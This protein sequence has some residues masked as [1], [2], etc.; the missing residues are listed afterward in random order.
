MKRF[1]NMTAIIAGGAG[2][3]GKAVALALVNEGAKLTVW[4][5][6]AAALNELRQEVTAAGAQIVTDQ[7]DVTDYDAVKAA[8]DK[9]VKTFGR[10]DIMVS[11]VGGGTFK[12]LIE[13][14]NEFWLK[15]QNYNLNSVFNCFH[16]SLLHMVKQEFGRLFCFMSTTGGVPGLAGY[17]AAKAGC[18]ALMEN[19]KAEHSRQH[20]TVNAVL[21]SFTPTPFSMQAFDDSE[22][23][24]AR[25]NAIVNR[26][27]LGVNTVENVAATVLDML[28]NER[29]SGQI[30]TLM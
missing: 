15:E 30:I 22:E 21:P 28:A 23:G 6:N 16:T 24:R 5:L 18:K 11:C 7:V 14:T 9:T 13:Y 29:I 17:G 25:Y 8:V 27:P 1:E 2:G 10:L 20:I 12:P 26:M 4:D 19:I 3:I